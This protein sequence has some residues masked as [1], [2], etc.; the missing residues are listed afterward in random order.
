[1]PLFTVFRILDIIVLILGL[2]MFKLYI[3]CT[4]KQLDFYVLRYIVRLL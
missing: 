1:M 3:C 4:E 2:I